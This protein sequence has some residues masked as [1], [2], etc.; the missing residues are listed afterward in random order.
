MR[1]RY[2]REGTLTDD[3]ESFFSGMVDTEHLLTPGRLLGGLLHQFLLIGGGV[4]VRQ[5]FV[6]RK[7]LHLNDRHHIMSSED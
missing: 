6:T 4:E 7:L 1:G 3:F 2:T 5:Q